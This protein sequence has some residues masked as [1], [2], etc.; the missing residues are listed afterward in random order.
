MATPGSVTVDCS[1]DMLLVSWRGLTRAEHDR[2][3]TAVRAISGA[4]YDA[5][6]KL[7]RVP[8]RQADRLYEALP[9]A[10]YSYDAI[11]AAVDA[12]ATRI[13]RFMR[14]LRALGVRFDLRAGR[15]LA[16]GDNVS[17]LVQQL[18]AERNTA[19]LAWLSE[20]PAEPAAA[21][22]P[23]PQPLLDGEAVRQAALL[24]QSLRNAA[25]NQQRNQQRD[26]QWSK[27]RRS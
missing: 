12:A 21:P 20:H 4:V 19:A 24:A 5:E 7:W 17:P 2:A 23:A 9:D 14:N 26:Q 22:A 18:V 25:K 3:V 13:D 8:V 10:S 11:C 6:E 1:D 16:L 27:Y 15:V